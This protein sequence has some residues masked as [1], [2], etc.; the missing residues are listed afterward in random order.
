LSVQVAVEEEEI[1]GEAHETAAIGAFVESSIFCFFLVVI[2]LSSP[3]HFHLLH[4]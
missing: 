3:E 4:L 2:F 1:E